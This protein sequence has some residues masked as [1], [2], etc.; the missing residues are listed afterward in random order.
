MAKSPE[1]VPVKAKL[2]K[3]IV[4]AL[5]FVNVT[6]FGPPAFPIAT[7]PHVSEVGDTVPCAE[8]LTSCTTPHPERTPIT[9]RT[10][11]VLFE[12]KS[13]EK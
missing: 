8:A 2:V 10:A 11:R 6:G 9:K 3:V 12:A 4:L 1:S 7:F 13:D 5:L